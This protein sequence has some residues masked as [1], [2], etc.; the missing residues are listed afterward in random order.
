MNNVIKQ[1][2]FDWASFLAPLLLALLSVALIYSAKHASSSPAERALFVKE[3][4]WVALGLIVFLVA[5]KIPLRTHE[6]MAYLYY[7]FGLLL[8]AALFVL[9]ATQYGATRWFNLGPF[10][11]QPSEI[12]KLAVIIALA[13]FL[14]YPKRA[15][16]NFWWVIAA[17]ALAG[18]PMLLVLRQ[19]DLGTS[20]IFLILLVSLLFWSGLSIYLIFLLVT[21]LLSVVLAFHWIP[22]G[23][24]FL[25]L[26]V[27]LFYSRPGKWLGVFVVLLNLIGGV[28]TP[29]L[30]NH[31]HDYQKERILAF[32]D[33]YKDPLGSGYQLIQSKV[34]IGS[35]GLL[36]KGYLH[37]SQARLEF[38]PMQHTDFIYSVMGEEFGLVGCFLILFLLGY[39]VYHGIQVAKKAR[40][41]FAGLL[42][43][44]IVSAI[45]FQSFV[46]IGMTLGMLPVTGIP[47]PFVSYGGSAMLV[48]WAM[49]GLLS[50]ANAHWQEY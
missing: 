25:G 45:G 12:M 49:W 42:A 15:F 24:F 18:V 3:A 20:L 29:L 14:A 2:R 36:G 7:A 8:L 50:N 5:Y 38:L 27:A 39:M 1:S 40:N 41:S 22:W 23:L 33:P 46:N 37:S 17:A 6:I 47:L 11:V 31:L 28:A 32:I 10:N 43:W 44:G 34:A 4:L 13:R 21:P 16:H 9:G 30:W 48:N 35:G 19:P 26:L